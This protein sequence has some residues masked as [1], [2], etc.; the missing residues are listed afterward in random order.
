[1]SDTAIIVL[2]ITWLLVGFLSL[3]ATWILDMRGEVY[4][5]YYFKGDGAIFACFLI[6]ALGY[7]MPIL[8][9]FLYAPKKLNFNFSFTRF[10][11]DLANINIKKNGKKLERGIWQYDIED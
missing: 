3:V 11:Y 8:I 5:P 4:D 1:M 2:V 10:I 9:F 7:I 6:V